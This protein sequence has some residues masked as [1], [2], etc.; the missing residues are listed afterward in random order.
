VKEEEKELNRIAGYLIKKSKR[1]RMKF[2]KSFD[3]VGSLVREW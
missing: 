3:F 1:D 2:G